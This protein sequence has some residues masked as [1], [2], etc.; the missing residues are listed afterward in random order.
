MNPMQQRASLAPA[1]IIAAICG[2]MALIAGVVALIYPDAD[3]YQLACGL[4]DSS[5]CNSI[6]IHRIALIVAG[7]SGFGVAVAVVVGIIVMVSSPASP[8]P[9]YYGPPAPPFHPQ[10]GPPPGPYGYGPPPMP[11]GPPTAPMPP[12]YQQ[13]YY[14][15]QPPA[16]PGN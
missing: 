11:Y 8:P 15:P 7:L 3:V 4:G 2:G 13:P 5:A 16:P 10:Y 6:E 12:Q 9:F 14:P 1:W